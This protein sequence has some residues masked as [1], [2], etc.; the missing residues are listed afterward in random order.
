M[1]T[2]KELIDKLKQYPDEM[3]VGEELYPFID[4]EVRERIWAR[5]NCPY[6][7]QNIEYVSL[8]TKRIFC[9]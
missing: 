4:I 5:S 2:V 7:E 3:L 8:T 6:E 9:Q 1:T